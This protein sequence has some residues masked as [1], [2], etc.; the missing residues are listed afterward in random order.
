MIRLRSVLVLVLALVATVLVSCGSPSAQQPTTYTSAQLQQI[1]SYLS[2]L[3]EMRDRLDEVP[4]ALRSRRWFDVSSVIHGPL[5][6]LRRYVKATT[7]TLLPKDAQKANALAED[8]FDSLVRL[9]EA[10]VANDYEL[11]ME[12]Y[13]QA[14]KD[15]DS[16]LQLVPQANAG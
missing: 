14:V 15:L 16:F 4:Y 11:G 10:A 8:L 2:P 9:D 12:Y 13:Q 1:Q 7:R 5:G 3:Q 6:E